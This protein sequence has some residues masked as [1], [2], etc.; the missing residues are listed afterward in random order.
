MCPTIPS[1]TIGRF[2]LGNVSDGAI[3]ILANVDSGEGG[4]ESI[5]RD[6]AR[7]KASLVCVRKGE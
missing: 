1:A 2:S 3:R 4:Y 6:M 7:D 5:E